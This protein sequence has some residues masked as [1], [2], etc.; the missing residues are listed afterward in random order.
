MLNSPLLA[1]FPA[2]S[3]LGR[4]FPPA[5]SMPREACWQGACW[6]R[7]PLQLIFPCIKDLDRA[8]DTPLLLQQV[9]FF[10]E[11]GRRS[12]CCCCPARGWRRRQQPQGILAAGSP[13]VWTWEFTSGFLWEGR[14]ERRWG[15]IR[16]WIP[17]FR[18]I[19]ENETTI[20]KPFSLYI[21]VLVGGHFLAL[22]KRWG[23]DVRIMTEAPTLQIQKLE[24]V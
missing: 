16:D 10:G 12:H 4:E 9:T 19:W 11:H 13:G 15:W 6:L 24:D 18:I 22:V 5:I 3:G 17:V 20:T 14:G 21:P 8:K 23:R 2:R 1:A 7:K